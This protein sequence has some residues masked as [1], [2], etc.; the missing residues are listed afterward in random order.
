MTAADLPAPLRD[1]VE[2][3]TPADLSPS[4]KRVTQTWIVVVLEKIA[5][6]RSVRLVLAEPSKE[7]WS[8]LARDIVM[9][10]GMHCAGDLTPRNLFLHLERLGREIPQ[11]LRD[12]PEMKSLD[13]VPS[14]GTRAVIIYKAMIAN[15]LL[16]HFRTEEPR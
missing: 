5:A 3:L 1:L 13:H 4:L 9:W 6:D 11:W 12:E 2:R 15:D 7:M 16:S 8:G 10:T 14:K